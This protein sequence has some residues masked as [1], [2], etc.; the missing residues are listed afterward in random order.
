M[1][2]QIYPLPNG[3]KRKA[4]E[5]SPWQSG[6]TKPKINGLYLREFDEGIATSEFHDGEWLRDGF[7]AS[8]IQDASWRGLTHHCGQDAKG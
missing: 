5:L 3:A 7:F 8:D 6:E 1:K 2:S 4:S